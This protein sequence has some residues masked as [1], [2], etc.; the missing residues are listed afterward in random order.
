MRCFRH[1]CRYL[2]TCLVGGFARPNVAEV[3]VEDGTSASERTCSS[4][5]KPVSEPAGAVWRLPAMMGHQP[6]TAKP[7]SKLTGG[8]DEGNRIPL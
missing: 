8:T 2:P 1:R 3:Q 6:H 4:C 5:L 7:M